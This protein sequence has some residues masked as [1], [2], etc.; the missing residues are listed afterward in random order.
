MM[1]SLKL[2]QDFVTLVMMDKRGYEDSPGCVELHQ[3]QTVTLDHLLV[4]VGG[5][6]LHDIVT[7]RVKRLDGQ[8]QGATQHSYMDRSKRQKL[9]YKCSGAFCRVGKPAKISCKTE[10]VNLLE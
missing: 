1:L 8:D 6:Q 5:V 10:K 3:P 7:G 4:E 2:L 9:K